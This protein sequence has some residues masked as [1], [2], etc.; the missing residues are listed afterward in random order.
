MNFNQL[1]ELYQAF[2]PILNAAK[3]ADIERV[4]AATALATAVEADK[5]ATEAA[6]AAVNQLTA[7]LDAFVAAAQPEEPTE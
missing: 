7:A 2:G 3:V 5:L 1:T 6:S 4:A